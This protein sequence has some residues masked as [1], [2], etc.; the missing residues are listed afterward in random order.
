MAIRPFEGIYPYIAPTAFVDETALVIGQVTIGRDASI[1][2]MAVV[3]GDVNAI[4]IG[5]RTNIQDG[6]VLHVT[7]D[8][9]Y[10]PGGQELAIAHDVTVGHHAVLHG[11][12][13]ESHCLIGIGAQVMDGTIVRS[14]ALIGAG[15]LVPPGKEIEGGFLWVGRPAKKVRAL[16]EEEL[17]HITY[18]AAH[19]VKNKN[20]HLGSR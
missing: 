8:G 20:R 1:W 15:A 2:P 9:P 18:S 6:S 10:S 7:H 16:T 13:V 12:T 14:H 3:R 4:V 17:A 5:E 11:C 19:Y